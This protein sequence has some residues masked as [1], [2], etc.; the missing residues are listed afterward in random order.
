MKMKFGAGGEIGKVLSLSH[1][2]KIIKNIIII[3]F[4]FIKDKILSR[5]YFPKY[6]K[7]IPYFRKF[8]FLKINVTLS[9]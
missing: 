9:Y 4:Y 2:I 5:Y 3:Y 6:S 1:T 7:E 8:Y